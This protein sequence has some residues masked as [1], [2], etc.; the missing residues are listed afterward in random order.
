LVSNAYFKQIF[1][2]KI[3]KRKMQKKAIGIKMRVG[4][5]SMSGYEQAVKGL[6]VL[7]T[8]RENFP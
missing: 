2:T 7:K 3:G 5:M 1:F 4:S 6:K 8:G